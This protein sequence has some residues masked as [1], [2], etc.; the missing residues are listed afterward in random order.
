VD[1]NG[2][3]CFFTSG[4]I[5]KIEPKPNGHVLGWV[6]GSKRM[7]MATGLGDEYTYHL[8]DWSTGKL[9]W[10]IED[11]LEYTPMFARHGMAISKDYLIL[12]GLAIRESIAH[13]P[14]IPNDLKGTVRMLAAIDIKKGKLAA[15]WYE[16][17]FSGKWQIATGL[18]PM[19]SSGGALIW[20]K[21]KLYHMTGDQFSE[22]DFNEI[23]NFENGWVPPD[24]SGRVIKEV[25]Y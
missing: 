11:P 3:M 10:S 9:V 12:S 8:L 2:N 5:T 17:V 22:I 14:V 19:P 23:K 24:N 15:K 21:G 4:R 1:V 25:I 18:P 7:I 13:G 16:P 6:D 20:Y